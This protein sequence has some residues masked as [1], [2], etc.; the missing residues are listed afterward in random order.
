VTVRPLEADVSGLRIARIGKGQLIDTMFGAMEHG[1]GGWVVTA[2][3]DFVRRAAREP[4]VRA[5]YEAATVRVAD[6]A[7]VVWATQVLGRPV[8]ERIT[9][10]SLIRPLAAR[11]SAS[12]RSIFLLGGEPGAAE[13]AARELRRT[14]PLLRIGVSC[15][16]VSLPPTPGEIEQTVRE[17]LAFS[18]DIVFAAFGSPK[19]ELVIR[20][21][22]PHL[23]RA[24]MVGVG[25]GLSYAAGLRPRAP[26]WMRHAGIEWVHRLLA[27]PGRLAGRYL[28][29]DAPF[30][31]RMLTEAARARLYER[32]SR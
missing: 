11:A 15:P 20:E 9:G 21:L 4:E 17:L 10:S 5:L 13:G 12:G 26:R 6:G 27:E 25:M 19:Q 30:A 18:P 22:L 16:S 2:N 23:P 24:W 31:V 14:W 29:Q 7:P 3:V 32:G 8:P 1:E 28:W